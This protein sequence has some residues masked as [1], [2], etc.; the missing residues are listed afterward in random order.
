MN[1][2][3]YF[4]QSCTHSLFRKYGKRIRIRS[5]YSYNNSVS[6]TE[7]RSSLYL[8]ARLQKPYLSDQ[9]RWTK[10]K[11]R[12]NNNVSEV[13]RLQCNISMTK[14]SEYHISKMQHQPLMCAWIRG[15][16]ILQQWKN[17][18]S[19][20]LWKKWCRYFPYQGKCCTAHLRP[21]RLFCPVSTFHQ[22]RERH[23]GGISEGRLQEVISACEYPFFTYTKRFHPHDPGVINS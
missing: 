23:G 9:T 11:P 10:R 15:S 20:A 6:V 2:A 19:V 17:N 8:A 7:S 14:A 21:S 12:C 1:L 16:A 5:G 13:T 4:L 22:Q 3:D 18:I